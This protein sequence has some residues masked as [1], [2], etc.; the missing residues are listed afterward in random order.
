VELW[1]ADRGT[2]FA[3]GE[4]LRVFD[5]FYRGRTELP[6]RSG[7]GIGLS[8]CRAIAEVHGG[9]IEAH[10]RPDGGA[11]VRVTIPNPEPPPAVSE[12]SF[13]RAIR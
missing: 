11:L 4:E 5:L 1:V 2:G 3:A 8:I 9:R 13:E 10:N 12:E 6:D 7:T